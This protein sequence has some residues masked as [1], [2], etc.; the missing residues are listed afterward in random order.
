MSSAFPLPGAL[1]VP[2]AVLLKAPW[3]GPLLM[4]GSGPL[5][6]S[7]SAVGFWLPTKAP[8]S[9]TAAPAPRPCKPFVLGDRSL[10]LGTSH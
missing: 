9:A 4:E 3:E 6:A 7:A 2:L 5:A 1:E 8:L 10:T